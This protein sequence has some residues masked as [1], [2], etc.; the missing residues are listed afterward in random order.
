MA[1][2]LDDVP[3]VQGPTFGERNFHHF[4]EMNLDR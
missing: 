4:S 1:K 3:L 2:K